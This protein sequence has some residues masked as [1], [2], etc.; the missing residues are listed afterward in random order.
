[1]KCEAPWSLGVVLIFG[2]F[3]YYSHRTLFHPGI[4]K[5]IHQVIHRHNTDDLYFDRWR[6]RGAT[7]KDGKAD[8]QVRAIQSAIDEASAASH[9]FYC[10]VW[11]SIG[12]MLILGTLASDLYVIPTTYWQLTFVLILI[13]SLGVI[14]DWRTSRWDRRA[15][16]TK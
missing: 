14:G 7:G 10:V 8:E 9:Y 15:F 6:R 1:M 16:D 11:N 4:N 2:I 13:F 5:L 12:M 3:V